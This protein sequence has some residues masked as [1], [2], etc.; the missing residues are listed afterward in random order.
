M[1][2]IDQ[3]NSERRSKTLKGNTMSILKL[4][5]NDRFPMIAIGF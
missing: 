4:G 1:I 5:K 3:K 2:A